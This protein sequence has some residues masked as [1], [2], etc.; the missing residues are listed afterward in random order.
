[1]RR[2]RS[3]LCK[4]TKS[5]ALNAPGFFFRVTAMITDAER[6]RVLMGLPLGRDRQSDDVLE[7]QMT[8]PDPKTCVILVP[9]SGSIQ[10]DCESALQTLERKGYPV[11]RVRGSSP[12]TIPPVAVC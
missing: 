6:Q 11:W 9:T 12:F 5:R 7:L 2:L 1:M 10:P 4:L 8:P 3:K